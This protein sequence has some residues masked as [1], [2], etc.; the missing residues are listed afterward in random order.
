MSSK[1]RQNYHEECEN[2][3]NKQINPELYASHTYLSMYSYFTR[4]D[5]AIY[6]LANFFKKQRVIAMRRRSTR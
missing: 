5:L 2:G 4:V 3:V 6:G 1:I